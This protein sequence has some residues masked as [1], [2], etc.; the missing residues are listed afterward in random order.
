MGMKQTLDVINRM[1]ADG[2]IGRYA[3]AGAVAAYNYVEPSVTE[4]DILISIDPP[5]CVRRVVWLRSHRSC[6]TSRTRGIPI[7]ARKAF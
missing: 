1:E 2:V 4:E 3:I 7:F 5:S 6:R